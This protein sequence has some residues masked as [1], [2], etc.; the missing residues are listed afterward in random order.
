MAEFLRE[1][2]TLIT[3]TVI[4]S[5]ILLVVT[6]V[7]LPLVLAFLPDDYFTRP[8][9]ARPLTPLRIFWLVLKN[10]LGWFLIVVG[11]FMLVLPG[12][13]LLTIF[14]GLLLVN[15]PG[16]YRLERWLVSRQKIAKSVNW[17]RQ[18]T[19]RPP[20]QFHD[21]AAGDSQFR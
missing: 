10:L 12:Q 11:I 7:A 13:G 18:R 4:A 1:H 21:D 3:I 15:F 16:K 17:I 14:V 6:L 8:P 19:G 9:L 5:A 20:L 2:D